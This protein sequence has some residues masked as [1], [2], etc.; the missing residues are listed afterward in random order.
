MSRFIGSH[1]QH[2]FDSYCKKVIRNEA[3][4]IQ[5][6]KERMRKLQIPIYN[7]SEKDLNSLQYEDIRIDNEIQ[8]LNNSIKITN[9]SLVNSISQLSE[10][11]KIII[12]LYYFFGFHDREIA[13]IFQKSI[14]GIWYQRQ[15]AIDD[16]RKYLMEDFYE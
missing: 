2:I 12:V 5:K 4:N 11:K 6:Q 3:R 15:M 14:S 9:D 13:K 7:L 1:I 8:I 16:L 10:N